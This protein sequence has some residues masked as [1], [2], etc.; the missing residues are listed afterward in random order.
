MLFYQPTCKL[1]YILA[2]RKMDLFAVEKIENQ[3]VITAYNCNY[4]IVLSP[5]LIY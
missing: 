5:I 3:F 2:T 1:L 4:F